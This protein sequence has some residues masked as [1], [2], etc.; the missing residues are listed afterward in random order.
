[1]GEGRDFSPTRE[2]ETTRVT[3]TGEAYRKGRPAS[4]SRVDDC[5]HRGLGDTPPTTVLI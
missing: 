4:H 1:M 2:G 3:Q 5:L